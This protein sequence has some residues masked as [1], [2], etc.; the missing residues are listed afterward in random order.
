MENKNIYDEIFDK[1]C[2]V[3]GK[4]IKKDV[5]DQ[6]EC[7]YCSWIN[8]GLADKNPN[9]V[10]YP[11]LISLNKARLL[12]AEGKPFQP[13]LDEFLDALYCYSEVQF[14]YNGT[15]YAVE[16]MG[17][18]I[19]KREISLFNSKTKE[20]FIFKTRDDFKNNAKVEGKLLKDIW[21]KT[22]DRYWLQ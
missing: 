4:I 5:Y 18:E 16:L 11:N 21:D 9:V 13:N 17:N 12:Y 19:E 3:C 1:P 14:E 10:L 6:G 2:S 20:Q 8:D 22:T 15:Y 7:P